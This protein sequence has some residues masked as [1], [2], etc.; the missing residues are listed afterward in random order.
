M[1][2]QL[3]SKIKRAVLD[4]IMLNTRW[5]CWSN[6]TRGF[7]DPRVGRF[8]KLSGKHNPKGVSDI[9]G[10]TPGGQ[11]VA[12]EV[13]SKKGKPSLEQTMFLNKIVQMGGIAMI[14]RSVEDFKVEYKRFIPAPA[15]IE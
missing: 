7:F 10:L 8:C 6:A 12:I 14:V 13:K 15:D 9:L 11:F 3:E 1:A 2:K 4:Y 5:Y